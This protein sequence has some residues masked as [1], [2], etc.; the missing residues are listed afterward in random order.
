MADWQEE[1]SRARKELNIPIET[2]DEER[3]AWRRI[4]DAAK[5]RRLVSNVIRQ[6]WNETPG[7]LSAESKEIRLANIIVEILETGTT[8]RLKNCCGCS[9]EF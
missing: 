8:K 5:R 7:K 9:F 1:L 6:Q 4:K 3:R 2:T